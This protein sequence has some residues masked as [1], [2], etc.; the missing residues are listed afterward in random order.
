MKTRGHFLR[1]I[2]LSLLKIGPSDFKI[3]ASLHGVRDK[4]HFRFGDSYI[5]GIRNS[6]ELNLIVS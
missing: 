5:Y 2:R 3:L 1:L 6:S 4:Q